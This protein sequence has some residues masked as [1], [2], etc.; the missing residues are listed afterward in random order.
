MGA[1][2]VVVRLLLRSPLHFWLSDTVLLLTYTGRKSGRR[3]T[4]PVSYSRAGD[5]VT[6]FTMFTYRSWW[7]NLRGGAPVR[8]EIKRQRFVGTAEAISD[9]QPA[10][11]ARLLAHLREH[12]SLAKGYNVP[13]DA[14]GRPDPNAVRHAARFVVMVQ[15]Q[16]TAT[17]RSIAVK[18][19]HI[20]A[21]HRDLLD[22][23][24]T[25]AL[26]TIMPDG[27]PQITPVWCNLDGDDV[28]VNTMRGFRKERNM[29]ANPRVTLLAYHSRQPLRHIEVRGSVVEMTEEEA[30]EH[31]DQ[32]TRLYLHRA[33]ARFFGDSVPATL[34]ATYVPVKV[35]IAP[36][37]IRVEG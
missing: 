31:L 30:L 21:S 6:M 10:T 35:R 36:T 25:A 12:P 13:L 1:A 32:L 29:R 7:R 17:R 37:L 24:Y 23:G 2:N 15:V 33:D 8:V 5:V 4:N 26:T 9:D 27:Q 34:R 18:A 3:Y 16:L 11:A 19:L 28:L 20:P 14:E 22:G